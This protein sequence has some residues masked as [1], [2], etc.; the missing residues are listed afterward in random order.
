M[1]SYAIRMATRWRQFVG[2]KW[3]NDRGS[4][5]ILAALEP[6]RRRRGHANVGFKRGWV[7]EVLMR[8]VCVGRIDAFGE[9]AFAWGTL[10]SVMLTLVPAVVVS[11]YAA[12][13][14]VVR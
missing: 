7:L 3:A 5:P 9:V 14:I 1:L 4:Q 11:V 2:D 6:R 8:R 10:F 12:H 13:G